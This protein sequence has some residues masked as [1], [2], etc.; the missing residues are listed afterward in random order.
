MLD[1]LQAK[2]LD[3]GDLLRVVREDADRRQPEVVEDLRADPVLAAV[4]GEAKLEVRLDGVEPVFLELVRLQLVQKADAPALLRH[5]EENAP[6]LV[7]D[8][9][10]RLLELLTTVA[11]KRVEHVAG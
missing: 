3:P 9:R 2:S 11:A 5:V 1:D 4:R 10:Q 6:L 8:S 7:T